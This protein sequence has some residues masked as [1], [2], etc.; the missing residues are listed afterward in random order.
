MA[1]KASTS[2]PLKDFLS[3][4][5]EVYFSTFSQ[6]PSSLAADKALKEYTSANR[7]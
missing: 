1:L 6:S 5:E 2:L 4:T 3:N 7:E